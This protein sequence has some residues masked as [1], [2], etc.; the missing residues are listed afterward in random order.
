[1][2]I[3]IEQ[4]CK[5]QLIMNGTG[6]DWKWKVNSGLKDEAILYP[7]IVENLWLYHNRKLDK[8]ESCS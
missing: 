8:V 5:E 1:M 3:A 4:A 2:G 7:R 6:L